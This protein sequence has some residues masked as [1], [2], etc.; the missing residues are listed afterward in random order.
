MIT[1]FTKWFLRRG[2]KGGKRNKPETP[3][4]NKALCLVCSGGAGCKKHPDPHR[5]QPRSHRHLDPFTPVN[6]SARRP[7]SGSPPGS[8]GT[9]A[10]QSGCTLAPTASGFVPP[11]TLTERQTTGYPT[12]DDRQTE[13]ICIIE[14]YICLHI[15][16]DQVESECRK[17]RQYRGS[18]KV[19]SV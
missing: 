1:A 3:L 16:L 15:K 8:G 18:S 7:V 6:I 17:R 4:F 14:A 13:T 2:P 11:Q 9:R 10:A 5:H 19:G 12:N